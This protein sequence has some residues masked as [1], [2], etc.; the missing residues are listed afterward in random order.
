MAVYFLRQNSKQKEET[1]VVEIAIM[2][3][4]LLILA[5]GGVVADYIFPHIKL[6][7][8]WIDTLPMA[9]AVDAEYEVIEEMEEAKDTEKNALVG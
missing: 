2:G 9:Q 1:I 8:K 6:L 5:A 4:F 3:G 7:N